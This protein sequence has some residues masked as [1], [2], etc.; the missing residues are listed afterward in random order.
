MTSLEDWAFVDREADPASETFH[1]WVVRNGGTA[2][3]EAVLF[4]EAAER[5]AAIADVEVLAV[6]RAAR[7]VAADSPIGPLRAMERIEVDLQR[8]RTWPESWT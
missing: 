2:C 8:G 4:Y 6:C 5:V 3:F 7:R 1:A